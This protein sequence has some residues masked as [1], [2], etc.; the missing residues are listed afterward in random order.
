MHIYHLDKW[1]HA[2]Q[3][4]HVNERGERN[5]IRVI[6]LTGAMMVIEIACGMAFGSMALL[7]DGWHM[8]THAAALGITAF[9]YRYARLHAYDPRYS[10]G[11][12]K[13]GVLGGYTSAVVLAVV[14]L[15]MGFESIHRFFSP[16][17]IR[18]NEAILTAIVGLAVNLFS[19]YLL[20]DS[21]DHE[22]H[23]ANRSQHH[24]HE[25]EHSHAHDHNLK[26]AYLHVLADA[27][28]SLLAIAALLA[29]KYFGW[30][31]MDPLMGVVGAVVIARWSHGL[32]KETSRILL[33][34]DV[35]QS[36][37]NA[38]YET[39]ESDS[40]NRI[41]DFHIW[42]LGE[43]RLAAVISIVTHYPKPPEHYKDLLKNFKDLVHITVEV[44][45]CDLD[46]CLPDGK[47]SDRK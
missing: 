6:W 4:H 40:D 47:I 25:H 12:G 46:P 41:V 38:V 21:H 29:G 5:T 43:K 27:L 23:H 39:I 26:A 31:K 17:T 18:F 1:K 2:H 10:F 22:H 30:V 14:A 36:T 24:E 13:V 34:R 45:V 28:T 11:T 20:R 42:K 9:A 37:V 15:L 3:F 8:G 19:A 7:A 35:S 44:N 32:M 16:T 33:D